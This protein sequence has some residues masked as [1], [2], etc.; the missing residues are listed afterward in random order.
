MATPES[1]CDRFHLTRGVRGETMGGRGQVAP[2]A[3]AACRAVPP[4]QRHETYMTPEPVS[5]L[6][7]QFL[8]W[9]TS[10]TRTYAEAMDAWR[11]SCPRLSVWEDA[12]IGGLIQLE[13]GTSQ[14]ALVRLTS[15]GRAILDRSPTE[16]SVLTGTCAPETRTSDAGPSAAAAGRPLE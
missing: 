3:E 14:Q 12:L 11:T 5:L 8:E 7:L 1:R 9:V 10:R 4:G 2:D 16:K 15:R 13:G 6:M